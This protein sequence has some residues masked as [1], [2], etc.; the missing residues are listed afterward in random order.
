MFRTDFNH[1]LQSFDNEVLYWFMEAISA[2]GTVM[3]LTLVIYILIAGI[4]FKK[5]LGVANIFLYT[6]V[7]TLFFKNVIDYPRPL[8][9][10][11]TLENFDR[12]SGNNNFDLQPNNFWELFSDE[13][14]TNIR[15]ND[16]AR[17]G[18]PSGHT[19]F[20]VALTLGSALLF[21]RKWLW[22][23]SASLVLLTMLSR[24]YLAQHYLGDVL[25]GL[26]VSVIT[27]AIT[28]A[29]WQR[30]KLSDFKTLSMIQKRFLI[31]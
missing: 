13:L 6:L 5:G 28:Y 19:A 11:T 30:L 7:L 16:N 23:L 29:I 24:M 26:I 22:Y 8:A 18:L 15:I 31:W 21:R 27:T 14:L 3:F 4:D 17:Y 25:G 12:S 9:V 2:L 1:Y 10:D 20:M